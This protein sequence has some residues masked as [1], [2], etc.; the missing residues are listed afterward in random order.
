[1]T[2]AMTISAGTDGLQYQYN[3]TG[4]WSGNTVPLSGT[5][6]MCYGCW[7]WP[8][9]CHQHHHW[10]PQYTYTITEPDKAALLKAWLD[11]F[12]TDRKMTEKALARVRKKIEE[13]TK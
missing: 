5:T 7:T 9:Q 2:T 4:E 10:Y 1:M 12:M 11:G 3:Q 8:C 13:F 6:G